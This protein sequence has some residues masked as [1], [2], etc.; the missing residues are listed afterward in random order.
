M[1]VYFYR[2]TEELYTTEQN[3]GQE[4]SRDYLLNRLTADDD[5]VAHAGT[6]RDGSG[7]TVSPVV[8][9]R[10]FYL[11]ENLKMLYCFFH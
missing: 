6:K 3:T 10:S 5:P 4:R 9:H 2:I 7:Q 11:D 8:Q 1:T